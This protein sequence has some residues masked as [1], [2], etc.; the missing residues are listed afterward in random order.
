MYA[1][2]PG[3]VVGEPDTDYV[4]CF[5]LNYDTEEVLDI[6]MRSGTPVVTFFTDTKRFEIPLDELV[7][8]LTRIGGEF[9]EI[10]NRTTG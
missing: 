5:E 1:P 3:G 2:V 9:E 7:R 8:F 10:K 4:P 6:S